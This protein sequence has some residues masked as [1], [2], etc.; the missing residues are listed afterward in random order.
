MVFS[1]T[2]LDIGFGFLYL[3]SFSHSSL[4]WHVQDFQ[5]QKLITLCW[6]WQ[7]EEVL[8]CILTVN[9]IFVVFIT[10]TSIWHNKAEVNLIWEI[11]KKVVT[12]GSIMTLTRLECLLKIYEL[13]VG[14]L[15]WAL[16]LAK[17]FIL[18]KVFQ[19]FISFWIWV[20]TQFGLSKNLATSSYYPHHQHNLFL[21][22]LQ[23]NEGKCRVNGMRMC[24]EDENPKQG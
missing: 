9:M 15:K 12:V 1:I 5:K 21:L 23:I 16:R 20:H 19:K 11:N 24:I 10:P 2:P 3:V 18:E 7:T 13:N 4:L 6:D 17:S 22:G 8:I 14:I